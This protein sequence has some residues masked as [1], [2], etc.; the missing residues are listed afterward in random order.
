M[1]KTKSKK[2]SNRGSMGPR[3][4]YSL[5]KNYNTIRAEYSKKIS[6]PNCHYLTF[7]RASTGIWVCKR[8]TCEYTRVG[9]AYKL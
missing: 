6:C 9:S 1:L 7:R 2:S 3:Y 5:T 4:G 8:K